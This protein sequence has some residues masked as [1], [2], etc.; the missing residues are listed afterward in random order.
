MGNLWGSSSSS[1]SSSTSSSSSSAG[2]FNAT[3]Q[4]E[5]SKDKLSLVS[6]LTSVTLGV[7]AAMLAL[8][9]Y[10]ASTCVTNSPDQQEAYIKA[11]GRRLQ[12][13]ERQISHNSAQMEKLL[14]ALQ[15]HAVTIDPSEFSTLVHTSQ[16]EAIKIALEM[17]TYPAPVMPDSVKYK[18]DSSSSSSSSGEGDKKWGD[19]NFNWLGKDGGEKSG[20]GSYST[21][22]DD[23]YSSSNYKTDPSLSSSNSG[24]ASPPSQQ[25]Q[26]ETLTDAQAESLCTE[27]KSKYSVVPGVSWGSLPY[28]LQQ[29]WVHYS[30]DYHLTATRS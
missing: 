20:V 22:F 18:Y 25:Q 23:L 24:G 21:K 4:K 29:K 11:V 15:A 7:G 26:W 2:S 6:I 27:M 28:D 1:S 12:D 19:D 14:S 16:S 10:H 13:V 17:V 5:K 30:C 3:F 9:Y 8:N